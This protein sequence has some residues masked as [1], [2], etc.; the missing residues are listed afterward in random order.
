MVTRRVSLF[1]VVLP[2]IVCFMLLLGLSTPSHAQVQ[3]DLSST[4]G[5][6]GGNQCFNVAG[7][8][9]TGTKF[10][11]TLHQLPRRLLVQSVGAFIRNPS[12]AD[13]AF[14]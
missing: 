7:L 11:G 13:A 4:S 12:D 10:L 9:T 14:A 6:C 8:F 1:T 3:V 2:A 5:L